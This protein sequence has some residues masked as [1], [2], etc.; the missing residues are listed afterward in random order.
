MSNGNVDAPKTG[1]EIDPK[2]LE[3]EADD[4]TLGD[5][6]NVD[7][8]TLELPS[9]INKETSTVA[10]LE[11][12]IADLRKHNEFLESTIHQNR[13]TSI[14]PPDN[15]TQTKTAIANLRKQKAE[16]ISNGDFAKAF[17]LDSE[18]DDMRDSLTSTKPD[19]LA[20]LVAQVSARQE[21]E[22]SLRAFIQKATWFDPRSSQYDS[23]MEGAAISI[24]KQMSKDPEWNLR[25]GGEYF[26]ELQRRTEQRFGIKQNKAD[27]GNARLSNVGGVNANRY[28]GTDRLPDLSAEEITMAKTFD[29]DNPNAVEDYA[30]EKQR[31]SKIIRRVI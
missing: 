12:T 6:T 21:N 19:E 1:E 23:A 15:R 2:T 9:V 13:Q 16:H 28:K 14:P 10:A 20:Q 22:Q 18:I 27:A 17:E 24:E 7:G 11:E 25:P 5:D 29:P 3:A 8:K 26:S 30:K 31:Q 4:Q